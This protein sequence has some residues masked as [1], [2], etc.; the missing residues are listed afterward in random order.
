[1]KL[2]VLGT[3]C[4]K[5]RQLYRNVQQ[6]VAET[7]VEA[8]VSKQRRHHGNHALQRVQPSLS[9]KRRRSG[10]RRSIECIRP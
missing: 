8:E 10:S 6:A 5:C 1:M 7:G 3:G 9:G 4:A 2:I